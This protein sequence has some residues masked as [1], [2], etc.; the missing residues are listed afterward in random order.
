MKSKLFL[1]CMFILI[2]MPFIVGELF[3]WTTENINEVDSTVTQHSYYQFDDTSAYWIGRTKGV[4]MNFVYVIEPLPYNLSGYGGEV[5]WCNLSINHLN[6]IYNSDSELINTTSTLYNVYTGGVT[7]LS[8]GTIDITVFDKDSILVD[9]E[10]HYTN[11][12]TLYVENVLVGQYTTYFP[13]FE[14]KGC[15]DYSLEELSNEIDRSDE[16][17]LDQTRIYENIQGIISLIFKLWLIV[18]WLI[19][20]AFVVISISLIF[21]GVYYLYHLFKDVEK[22]I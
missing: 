15:S 9:M 17:A 11:S 10:C 8:T 19:K 1:I 13:S 20:I 6:H 2:L 12:S 16:I 22:N 21:I 7:N 18:N 3:L 14:C 4:I 5:D